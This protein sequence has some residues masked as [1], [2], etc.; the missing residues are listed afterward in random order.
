MGVNDGPLY[1]VAVIRPRPDRRDEVER[2]L[3][4]MV[5][6]AR[7]EPGCVRMDLVVED[8]DDD[9]APTWCMLEEFR[10]RADWDL[11]MQTEH[12]TEGNRRLVGLLREPTEL[13]LYT[14][15]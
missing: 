6:G 14:D 7:R 10:S 3:R 8:G 1:L 2:E 5:A 12:V 13:H 11:H 15:K 9:T 4:T